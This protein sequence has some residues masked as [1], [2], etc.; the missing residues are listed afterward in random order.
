[1]K[2]NAFTTALAVAM[3]FVGGSAAISDPN[4][5]CLAYD[6]YC[7]N[8]ACNKLSSTCTDETGKSTTFQY[9]RQQPELVGTCDVGTGDCTME[10]QLSCKTWKYQGNAMTKCNMLVCTEHDFTDGCL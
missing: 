9:L 8:I 10:P 6:E 1:M 5:E 7:L 4:M 2:I 3:I